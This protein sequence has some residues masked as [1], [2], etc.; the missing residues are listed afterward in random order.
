MH[1]LARAEPGSL[2]P[3]LLS[4]IV[5]APLPI[6]AI[7][8]GSP[9]LPLL[10]GAAAAVLAWEWARLC[11]GGAVGISGAA[12]I[13]AVVVASVS[14]AHWGLATGLVAA[15]AGAVLVWSAAV[16]YGDREPG[17]IAFGG[18]WLGLPCVLLLWLA[19]PENAGRNLLLWIFAVVWA[20]DIGA[21]AVGRRL[22]G[23]RLA[24]RWSPGKTWTGLAGGTAAAGI[25]GW[26]TGYV[27][28][29][30]PALPLVMVS[31]GLAVV[32]QFGDLAESMAK[33][34]FGVKDS[35]GLIPGHG[36][37]LDRVDGLLAVIPVAALL[38]VIGGGGVL[39]WR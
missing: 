35:S 26:V 20:T 2:I 38:T 7:W 37:L 28:G 31:T 30:S 19:G 32:E 13:A 15:I 14:A 24:P 5:L 3:R 39:S 11:R 23:P 21:Y 10:V 8:F 4:A 9:W 34:R 29:I 6:A 27:L 18:L 33:R 1:R 17:W 36:G 16:I 25:A 22:G 12:L